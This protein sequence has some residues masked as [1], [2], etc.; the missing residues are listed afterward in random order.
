MEH[1]LGN[2]QQHGRNLIGSAFRGVEMSGV[3]CNKFLVLYAVTYAEFIGTYR[4]A[5]QADTEYLG[6]QAIFHVLVLRSENPVERI[7]EQL[8]IFHA[9]YR[10]VL[11]AVVYPKVH[12]TWVALPA[13]HF[14]CNGTA[15]LGMLYPK[16]ADAL[17]RV[18]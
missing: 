3:D 18:G 11:A 2:E 14:L 13:S 15:T 12:D 16:V 8:A 1:Q 7:L 9:V 17:I 6:L 10:N 5:F 4:V